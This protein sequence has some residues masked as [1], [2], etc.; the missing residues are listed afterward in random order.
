MKTLLAIGVSPRHE[1]SISRKLTSPESAA[2]INISN[3]LVAELRT[4]VH[5][6]IGT[7][8]YNFSIPAV[9]K[10]YIDHIVRVGL[11][12]TPDNVSP[13]TGKG[14]HHP[15]QRRRLQPGFSGRRLQHGERLPAPG[16]GL[17]RRHQC[18]HHPTGVP[19]AGANGEKAFEQFGNTITT[20]A[21]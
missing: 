11:T 5:I 9:L 13:L 15:R 1:H 14:H 8:M 2:A 19:R 18:R 3:D 4:A 12:F 21:A 7:Q 6:V 10:A 16:A 17:Y 20:A